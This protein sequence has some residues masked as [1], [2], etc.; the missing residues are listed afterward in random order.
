MAQINTDIDPIEQRDIADL[1]AHKDALK[2][3]QV[4]TLTPE[5]TKFIEADTKGYNEILFSGGRGAGKSLTLLCKVLEYLAYPHSTVALIRYNYSD[6]KKTTV[7]LL[8]Y[9]ETQKDGTWRPPLLPPQNIKCHN[10]I[11]GTI[12]LWNGS[13]LMLFG[14]QDPEKLKSLQCSACFV[15]EVSQIDKNTYTDICLLP[16]QYH[17]LGNRIYAATNPLHKGHYLYKR[18][19]SDRVATR[20]IIFVDSRSNPHLQQSYIDMLMGLDSEAQ[21]RQ[22]KGEWTDTADGVFNRFDR[23]LHVKKCRD[24]LTPD[25][26]C[27]IVIGQDLGGGSQYAGF[28][29]AGKGIDGKIYIGIEHSKKAITH[30]EMLQ[31]Q[32]PFRGLV[33]STV[34]YDSANTVA[35][36]EMENA[37]WKCIPCIKNIDA[38]VDLMN[39]LLSEDALIIDPACE[40]LIQEIEEAHRNPETGRVN[41]TRSW[42]M[43]DA[44]R[45][46]IWHLSDMSRDKQNRTMPYW[47]C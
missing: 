32:E 22:L 2:G 24:L 44:A 40:L 47:F 33:H 26:C 12:E 21:K 10:K 18:F 6:L 31:W 23:A 39:S 7:R 17:P 28:V 36:N 29:I 42:D 43:I 3:K 27:E 11:D 15:E 13:V 20:K 19:V 5:Q 45:Y 4:I 35:K 46:A 14:C 34:V 9:G 16:R 37:Q 8:L 41:T 38:S 25:N 30:R 1:E